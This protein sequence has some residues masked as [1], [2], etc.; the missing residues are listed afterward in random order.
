[1]DGIGRFV[2]DAVVGTAGG[3][4]V[5][6][7]FAGMYAPLRHT[8]KQHVC[9]ARDPIQSGAARTAAFAVPV[10][11]PG[12]PREEA[13]GDGEISIGTKRTPQLRHGATIQHCGH[14]CDRKD[15]DRKGGGPRYLLML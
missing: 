11:C 8:R 7:F 10:S 4:Y 13:H 15:A 1:M 3:A 2:A 5:P 14:D 6:A 9:P 12:T